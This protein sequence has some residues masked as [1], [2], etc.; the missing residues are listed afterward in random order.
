MPLT[1]SAERGGDVPGSVTPSRKGTI[2]NQVI[3]FNITEAL[4]SRC[5]ET[6]K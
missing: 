6:F 4:Y 3:A 2:T 1:M 5:C